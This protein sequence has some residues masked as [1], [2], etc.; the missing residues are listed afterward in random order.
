MAVPNRLPVVAWP[1]A[2]RGDRAISIPFLPDQVQLPVVPEQ[3]QVVA[4][5]IQDQA[6]ER[7]TCAQVE[8]RPRGAGAF[9][10]SKSPQKGDQI[11]KL[12]LGEVRKC[13]HAGG[14]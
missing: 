14:R 3:L 12:G 2:L 5:L 1:V 13:G 11:P 8:P 7:A 4:T 10:R 9:A 6:I